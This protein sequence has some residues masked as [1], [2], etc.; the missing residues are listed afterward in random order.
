MQKMGIRWNSFSHPP[1][2]NSLCEVG[3]LFAKDH[4]FSVLITPGLVLSC[5]FH[6][7]GSSAD[8]YREDDRH[9]P[10]V[11]GISLRCIVGIV[12]PAQVLVQV[13]NSQ[14][15]LDFRMAQACP[16][17]EHPATLLLP[18]FVLIYC[19]LTRVEGLGCIDQIGHSLCSHV[20]FIFLFGRLQL[21]IC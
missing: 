9:T 13:H 18:C 19:G 2:T 20:H 12:I 5:V 3:R 21:L 17:F 1:P 4:D 15:P 16:C 8:S 6:F 7:P 11:C 10:I 14:T